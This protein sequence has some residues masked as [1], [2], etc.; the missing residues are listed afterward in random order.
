MTMIPEEA[1]YSTPQQFRKSTRRRRRFDIY[2]G[3][4]GGSATNTSRLTFDFV[5][6]ETLDLSTLTFWV[7]T[8]GS[9]TVVIQHQS[10]Q[11]QTQ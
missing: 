8:I 9:D 3:L 5:S 4:A 1:K 11:C 7:E 6:N 2:G 10:L